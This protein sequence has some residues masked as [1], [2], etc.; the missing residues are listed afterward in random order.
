MPLND[1]EQEILDEIERQLYE[2]DPK[3]AEM[4]SKAVRGGADRW[5]I[6]LAAVMFVLG[7][8]VMFLSFT[9]TVVVAGSG[10]LVMVISAGWLVFT[11]LPAGFGHSTSGAM[12]AWL[13]RL[14]HR[15]HDDN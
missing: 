7:A 8:V 3:L 2:E 11:L 13:Q 6:R 5:K 4:V 10:F 15:Q 9:R 14:Q 1:H 12:D